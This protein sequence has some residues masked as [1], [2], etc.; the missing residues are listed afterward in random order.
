MDSNAASELRQLGNLIQ[1][2]IN[3]ILGLN[4]SVDK[5]VDTDATIPDKRLFDAQRTLLSAAGKLTELVS[6][7]SGRLLEVS[8]QYYE[9]RCLHIAAD[10]RIP[11]L[12]AASPDTGVHIDT[13]SA[14]VGIES[15]KLC[16][17]T[18]LL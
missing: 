13:L 15:R 7:P 1:S 5:R 9:A 16:A 3:A 8:S 14:A 17:L 2:S 10:K 6:Q 18:H 11:D 12:L 4:G